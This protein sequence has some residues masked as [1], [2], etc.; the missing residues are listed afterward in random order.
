MNKLARHLS[1]LSF[2]MAI[3]FAPYAIAQ[4]QP[5]APAAKPAAP[6][7]KPPA[8]EAKPEAGPA[9]KFSTFRARVESESKELEVTTVF[10]L[11]PDSKGI[12]PLNQDVK[13]SAGT[14]STTIP[15]GS[16]KT[17]VIGWFEYEGVI[18]G[19]DLEVRIAPLGANRYGLRAEA[20]GKDVA[21]PAPGPV[22][23]EISIGSDTG[24][25]MAKVK[26]SWI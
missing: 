7:A 26:R 14:F 3:L 22:K 10:T 16:F 8:S 6:A 9:A 18:N 13:L 11:G 17:N 5:A 1:V 2:A 15:A 21:Q 12:N 24:V 23:V 4:T 19:V 20:E 25:T